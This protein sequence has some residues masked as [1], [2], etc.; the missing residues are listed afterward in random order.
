MAAF[1]GT[2]YGIRAGD[3]LGLSN[4]GSILGSNEAG[5]GIAGVA[6]GKGAVIVNHGDILG[7]IDGIVIGAA[8]EELL[9]GRFEQVEEKPSTITNHGYITGGSGHGILGSDEV[10]TITNDG[11]I[12]GPSAIDLAGGDDVI[13]L[14]FGSEVIG[15]VTG[16]DGKDVLNFHAGSESFFDITNI[17]HGNVYGVE[18]I[19][20]SDTGFAFIG[21]PGESFEVFTDRIEVSGGGLV[22]N[23]N[24]ASLDEGKTQVTLTNGGRLDGTGKWNADLVVASGGLSA[25]GTNNLLA[26]GVILPP[27]VIINPPV[28]KQAVESPVLPSAVGTLTINGDVSFGG[29]EAAPKE[30][31]FAAATSTDSHIRVD[32]IP[33]T[34]IV[35][36]VNS[37]LIIQNGAGNTF[38]LGN[39]NLRLA[40]TDINKTLTNGGYTLVDSDS[41]AEELRPA[42]NPRRAVQ[43]QRAG[44]GVF[45]RYGK[46]RKQ[47]QHGAD[48][49]FLE[50]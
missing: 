29:T 18:T 36:G 12:T 7:D 50:G 23:G 17:V 37:D 26:P 42:G 27:P 40:P 10:E 44:H 30:A 15:D 19:T 35:N 9:I 4:Y 41:A 39:V 48:A 6:A 46:R 21:A 16:G 33:Q 45:L 38:D 14:D 47:P 1:L 43:Q 13:N 32:I 28:M 20:K 24:L 25:G 2:N 5:E 49:V 22:I 31:S 11:V 3:E 34:E 8:T